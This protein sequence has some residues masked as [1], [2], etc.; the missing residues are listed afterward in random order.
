MSILLPMSQ[1]LEDGCEAFDIVHTRIGDSVT[2]QLSARIAGATIVAASLLSLT[3]TEHVESF[4]DDPDTTHDQAA[5]VMVI[6]WSAIREAMAYASYL[7]IP[8]PEGDD[9][10]RM[11]ELQNRMKTI[12]DSVF[13]G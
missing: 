5:A 12:W 4:D 13:H 11:H 7:D 1:F 8:L 6:V 3:P 9:L 2:D 10:V